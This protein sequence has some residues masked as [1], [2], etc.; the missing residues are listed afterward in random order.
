[1][2]IRPLS[3]PA[4]ALLAAS[5]AST[6]DPTYPTGSLMV[7]NASNGWIDVDIDGQRLVNG[8]S[9]NALTYSLSMPQGLHVVRL[10]HGGGIGGSIELRVE[11]A[12][13]VPRTVVVYPTYPVGTSPDM[14]AIVLPDTGADVPG[15]KSKLRV[16]H[17]AATAGDLQIWRREPSLPSGSPITTRMTYRAVS[18]YLQGDA[19]VW[20][21]WLTAPTGGAKLLSSGPIQI[22][23]GERRSVLLVDTQ[24]GPRFVVM[25]L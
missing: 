7:A 5:C 8:L 9:M 15:G 16:V 23:S 3:L 24:E 11:V 18:P 12:V 21:V 1:M 14:S 22:P 6:V 25:G 10:S 20:E 2:R 4:L 19:G 13:E 17:L